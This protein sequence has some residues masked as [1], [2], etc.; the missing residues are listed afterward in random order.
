[1]NN[2]VDAVG[3]ACPMPV[4]KA[5]RALSEMKS[6]TLEV[7]VDNDVAVENLKRMAGSA[8]CGFRFEKDGSG[9]FHV[10]ILK[11]KETAAPTE[12]PAEKSD[13]CMP[14]SGGSVTAAVISSETMG[15]GDDELGKILMRGF[16]FALTQMPQ[17]PSVLIKLTLSMTVQEM[18]LLWDR[19]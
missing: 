5:K 10:F 7:L 14:C 11:D 2:K 17:P 9:V 4:I 1:M 15:S 13:A 6:G 3:Q 18:T 19:R 16:I 8:E 12:D